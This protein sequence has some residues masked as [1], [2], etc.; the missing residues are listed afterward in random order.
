ML[1]AGGVPGAPSGGRSGSIRGERLHV[2]HET[3]HQP[4]QREVAY[5]FARLGL[6]RLEH[7]HECAAGEEEV[8][9]P[10]ALAEMQHPVKARAVCDLDFDLARRGARDRSCHGDL[11]ARRPRHENL[12]GLK[13]RVAERSIVLH[14]LGAYDVD[15][16]ALSAAEIGCERLS[17]VEI[18]STLDL[19]TVQGGGSVRVGDGFELRGRVR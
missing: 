17:V 14:P 15:P 7:R 1:P 5:H 16:A 9:H 2:L 11:G 19:G 4:V 8:A 3:D 12:V 6:G 18:Q 13:D 10:L